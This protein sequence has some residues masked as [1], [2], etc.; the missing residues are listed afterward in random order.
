VAAAAATPVSRRDRG[1]GG[2]EAGAAAGPALAPGKLDY[3]EFEG[4]IPQGEYGGGTVMVWGIGT[5]EVVDGSYH[6]G[7]LRVFLQGR[8]LRGEW[9]LVRTRGD[10]GRKWLVIKT[11]SAHDAVSPRQDDASALT[12]RT[13][14]RIA[15]NDDAQW[16]SSRAARA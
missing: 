1:G 5:Y 11:G 9:T 13:M 6:A 4:T 2:R 8:K 15:E 7:K 12:G 3:L 14:A 10:D 16:K